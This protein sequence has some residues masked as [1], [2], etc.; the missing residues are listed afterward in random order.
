[1]SKHFYICFN[2]FCNLEAPPL[3]IHKTMLQINYVIMNLMLVHA[4][5]FWSISLKNIIKCKERSEPQN[6]RISTLNLNPRSYS[7]TSLANRFS[8]RTVS[9]INDCQQSEPKP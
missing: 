9:L 8:P 3:Y 1:M 6:I 4:S 5:N 2:Y 7:Y